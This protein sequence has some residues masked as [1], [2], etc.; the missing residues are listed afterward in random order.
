MPDHEVFE[1]VSFVAEHRSPSVL[2]ISAIGSFLALIWLRN[3]RSLDLL[4]DRHALPRSSGTSP[5]EQCATQ[6]P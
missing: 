3:S 4:I 2:R 5:H 1:S 6:A